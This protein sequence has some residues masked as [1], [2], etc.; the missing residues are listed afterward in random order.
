MANPLKLFISYSHKDETKIEEFRKHLSPLKTN[1]LIEDWYDR[2]IM[3]GDDF[4]EVID[5]NIG[6]ADIICLLISHNF[7]SSPACLKEIEDAYKLRNSK[8]IRV[9]CI[10]L[11]PCA[12][13]DCKGLSKPL[14]YPTDGK[15]ISSF[16]DE[17][18]G[19]VDVYKGLKRVVEYINK[20]S[21]L[22]LQ[23]EWV[24]ELNNAT[25]FSKAHPH[26]DKV[27]L[28]D[29]FVYPEVDCYDVVRGENRIH[30]AELLLDKFEDKS[31]LVIVGEDQSGK[32][33][34]AK[35]YYKGLL[36]KKYVPVLIYDYNETLLGDI[37][38][39]IKNSF[40]EQYE[41]AF[42]LDIDTN[43][44]VP[45]IDNFHKA[46]N[47]SKHIQA[48][49][50]YKS[51]ILIVDD[52][53]GI[54]IKEEGLLRDYRHYKIR[55]YKASLR[56]ELIRKW[57]DL[58][59]HT[60]AGKGNGFYQELD[61]KTELVNSSLGKV[62]GGGIMPAFP[63][64]ILSIISTYDT[65][66]KPLD[67]EITSQGYCYQALIFY[68]L[69]KQGVKS[70]D[71]DFYI[72]FLSEFAYFIYKKRAKEIHEDDLFAF[73]DDYESRF[74]SKD[75]HILL[76]HLLNT[77]ILTKSSLNN[78]SFYYPYLYYFFAA[79]Y[80]ADKLE[81]ETVKKEIDAIIH[82][83]HT[84]E[85]AYIAIFIAHH[86]KSNYLIDEITLNAMC[87][88]DK[89]APATLTKSE[90]A[91][92]EQ[93]AQIVVDATLPEKTN[94]ERER[95]QELQ[96]QDAHEEEMQ[97][98]NTPNTVADI[99]FDER[100]NEFATEL[101]RSIKTVEVMGHI[102]KN[103][104]GSLERGSLKDIF[105][106]AMD[107]HL[108]ILSYFFGLIQ[109]ERAIQENVDF[110][111]RRLNSV[112]EKSEKGLSRERLEHLAKDIFWNLNFMVIYGVIEKIMFSLGSDKL[113]NIINEACNERNT[114]AS[115]VVKHCILMWYKKNLRLS[116]MDRIKEKDFSQIAL[117]ILKINVI[118]HCRLHVISPQDSDKIR[119]IFALAPRQILQLKQ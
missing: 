63:F 33:S 105:N 115:F 12:W 3:G 27:L 57:I 25:V 41:G 35:I 62:L 111:L 97:L 20:I 54:N 95:Y 14:A 53:T 83:L 67:Q 23:Q 89:N 2:K 106:N 119:N 84:N 73:F 92:F 29:I 70:D 109:D 42:F 6:D 68:F 94:S 65:F 56:A 118:N 116:E 80:F 30:S 37:N 104:A 4:Q 99:E 28:D 85:N 112:L 32:T 93:R 79:K 16:D 34:L 21:L 49:A 113:I 78:Y 5:N 24:D 117:N 17:N 9:V 58:D 100:A 88:F 102:I 44:I 71:I 22:S 72:N 82:N 69:S 8:G 101:R 13:T 15:P 86:S 98:A 51:T 47:K 108:R 74:N 59:H 31:K 90:L 87:M 19:W 61:Q 7:I 75:R 103:R 10:I 66:S 107:V 40:E 81:S 1:G 60:I 52:I 55:E 43:R 39:R 114:P 38:N 26:K 50:E 36:A 91:F 64:F 18:I 76:G 11:S 96:R 48:L 45:I 46:K 77:Q 110:I